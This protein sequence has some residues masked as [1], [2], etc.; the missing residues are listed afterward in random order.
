MTKTAYEV[1][2]I[3]YMRLTEIEALTLCYK[4]WHYMEVFPGIHK[5]EAA[6]DLKEKYNMPYVTCWCC[7]YMSQHTGGCHSLCLLW[8]NKT[9]KQGFKN[10]CCF[11]DSPYSK[12][13]D[14]S[15][16]IYLNLVCYSTPVTY[17]Q[18]K[19]LSH[20]AGMIANECLHQ[21]KKRGV[22]HVSEATEAY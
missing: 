10:D 4:H 18:L 11:K 2:P 19:L 15:S 17:P 22:K 3:D 12:W 6:L 20:Y 16:E 7:E 9:G 14:L 5:Y 8:F 1:K 21:L 13:C